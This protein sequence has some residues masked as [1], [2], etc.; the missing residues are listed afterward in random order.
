MANRR[1]DQRPAGGLD[2]GMAPDLV[3]VAANGRPRSS[4]ARLRGRRPVGV[5][6]VGHSPGRAC[7]GGSLVPGVQGVLLRP[8]VYTAVATPNNVFGKLKHT[9]SCFRWG[10]GGVTPSGPSTDPWGKAFEAMRSAPTFRTSAGT[11]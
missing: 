4:C 5:P 9:F 2:S 7:P 3:C 1:Q 8:N 10:F 6:R 11:D